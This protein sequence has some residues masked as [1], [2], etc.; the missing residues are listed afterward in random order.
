[1]QQDLYDA[2]RRDKNLY[3]KNLIETQD[4]LVA[5]KPNLK[6]ML[7]KQTNSKQIKR[8]DTQITANKQEISNLKNK[9]LNQKEE[10]EKF[11]KKSENLRENVPTLEKESENLKNTFF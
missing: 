7:M 9:Y 4:D 3:F 5:R 6:Q 2:V 10:K 1:M 8:K 11:E